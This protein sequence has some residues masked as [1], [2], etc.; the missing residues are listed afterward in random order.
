MI[1]IKIRSSFSSCR[2]LTVCSQFEVRFLV[3]FLCYL[4][5]LYHFASLSKFS[6]GCMKATDVCFFWQ[7]EKQEND[8]ECHLSNNRALVSISYLWALHRKEH[9][10]G[11]CDRKNYSLFCKIGMITGFFSEGDC[12]YSQY[13]CCIFRC[14]HV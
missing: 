13:H 4:L 11:S 7:R 9:H 2:C 6:V 14:I 3:L 12:V 8:C 1:K 5:A 10:E